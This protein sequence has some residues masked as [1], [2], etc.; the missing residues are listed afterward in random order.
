M[1]NKK[2]CAGIVL[3][4]PDIELLKKNINSIINQVSYI[5]MYDNSSK[6]IDLVEKDISIYDQKRMKLIKGRENRGIAYALNQILNWA[7]ENKYEWCLT[8]DQD[9]ICDTNMINEYRKYMAL[10]GVAL[11]CP[12]VLNNSKLTVKEFTALEIENYT[13]VIKPIDCI[14]SGCLNNVDIVKEIGGYCE[15]LF[16]DFVDTEINCRVLESG[17]KIIKVNSTYLL[18]KMGS[19]KEVRLFD[20]LFKKTGKNVFRKLRVATVYTDKRLYY[21]SRNS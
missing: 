8:M 17:Y 13:K 6:N 19:K 5:V 2:V 11:I 4:N 14:T 16:I 12:Y 3:Y 10:S 9:S 20:W 21:S 18:Q 15:K 1:D 7:E